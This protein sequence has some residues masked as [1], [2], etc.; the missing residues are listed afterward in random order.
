[1]KTL[2]TGLLTLGL[3]ATHTAF[4]QDL[5]LPPPVK[6]DT[7][8]SQIIQGERWNYVLSTKPKFSVLADVYDID[9]FDNT[10]ATV[11]TI[12]NQGNK[13]ICYLS[14]GTW[15]DWRPDAKQFP[16]SVKGKSNGWPGEKWL[17]IRQTSILLPIMQARINT[18]KQKGFDAVEF[19]NVDGY[20]NK[21]GFPLKSADQAFYNASLANMA[22]QA[23]LAVGLKNDIDQAAQLVNY[24]DFA[25][26]EQCFEYN[27]CNTLTPFINANKAVLNVEYNLNTSRFCSKANNMRFS[28]IK[29]DM[30]LTEKV[31]FCN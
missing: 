13:A 21:T 6:C 7:C 8:A 26:N 1:M 2:R 16:A 17:D 30:E 4:T 31:T 25:I 29:K 19:D 10:A 24:F 18:C 15:E 28:S 5:A 14:A 3:L 11:K 20:T 23:G 12:H 27:E 9:G 22:H